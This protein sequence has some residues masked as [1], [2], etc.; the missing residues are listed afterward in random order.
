MDSAVAVAQPAPNS[1]VD[2][3]MPPGAPVQ[4]EPVAPL[5]PMPHPVV[6]E[7]GLQDREA[8][9]A[10]READLEARERGLYERDTT[11]LTDKTVEGLIVEEF[12]M[13]AYDG[14]KEQ[15][16]ISIQAENTLRCVTIV[17][18]ILRNGFPIVGSS[19]SA[20][21]ENYDANEGR[22]EA[23]ADALAKLW[24]VAEYDQ[25]SRIMGV[26]LREPVL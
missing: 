20:A 12:S 19:M 10:R 11:P 25:R 8:D 21:P 16:N 3:F 9:L 7:R 15:P 26:P 2:P 24:L 17:V 13:L 5:A 14:F 1:P 18:L 22:K 4:A 23:R 6:D